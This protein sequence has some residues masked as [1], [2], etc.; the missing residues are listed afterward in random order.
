MPATYCRPVEDHI[1]ERLVECAIALDQHMFVERLLGNKEHIAKRLWPDKPIQIRGIL[2]C[3]DTADA[4][5][6]T[7][8]RPR[9]NP[10]EYEI[11][12]ANLH[13]QFIGK[14]LIH[15]HLDRF[16]VALRRSGER[17]FEQIDLGLD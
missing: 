3:P 11:L 6:E 2:R 9:L 4:Y 7:N 16:P 10:L 14:V 1:P 12:L 15:H 8:R 13:T 17:A 5:R